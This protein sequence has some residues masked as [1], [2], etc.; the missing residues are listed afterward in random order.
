MNRNRRGML[1]VCLSV[2]FIHGI[3]S[4]PWAQQRPLLIYGPDGVFAPMRECAELF[5]QKSGIEAK[6]VTAPGAGW[7][8]QARQ[9]AD[10]IYEETEAGLTQFMG[11]YPCLVDEKT[12]TSLYPRPAGILVRKGNPKRIGSIADLAREGIYL[13]DVNG[14]GQIGLWEDVAGLK[15]VIPGIRKNIAMS[16]A[17]SAEAIKWW[18][19]LPDLDAWITFES[20]SHLLKDSAELVRLP[21]NERVYRGTALVATEF[22]KNQESARM[23]IDFLKTPEC[24]VIFQKWGWE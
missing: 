13:L 6:V 4:I 3:P 20:S 7:I 18:N 23:F 15:G 19:S 12:R 24:H 1:I 11:D 21:K 14:S 10:I 22:Y 9:E 8:R 5:S 2:L 17:T 16:T